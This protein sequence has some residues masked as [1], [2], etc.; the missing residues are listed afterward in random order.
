MYAPDLVPEDEMAR[1]ARRV[2]ALE[3]RLTEIASADVL[4]TAGVAAEP[5]LIRI[6][7]SLV[8]EGNLSVPNGSIDNDALSSPVTGD[9]ATAFASG[10]ALN[11]TSAAHVPVSVA[12]PAGFTV[13]RVMA[14]S[15]V[16]AGSAAVNCA[17]RIEASTG[18]MM[19]GVYGLS[20][21]AHAATFTGLSG[22]T[23]TAYTMAASI[24]NTSATMGNTTIFALFF[25]A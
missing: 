4:K 13:A 11:G 7:G 25:R 22:G 18:G 21:S 24:P 17:T 12:V 1:M 6:L 2:E 16:A 19:T 5:D 15:S 3:R 10:F 8:V 14:F 23:I 9:T 20:T